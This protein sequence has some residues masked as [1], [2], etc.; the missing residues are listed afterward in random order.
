MKADKYLEKKSLDFEIV[1]QDN[2]TLDCDDAAQER[3]VETSQIAK[4]LIVD[5]DGEKIHCVLPGDRT[6]SA[7]KFG[8]NALV[9][10]EESLEITGQESG[11]VHPFS[12]QL[13]HRI[14][15]R[16]LEEEKISFTTGNSQKGVIIDTEKFREGLEKAGFNFQIGDIVDFNR[17]DIEELKSRGLDEEEARFVLSRGLEQEFEELNSDHDTGLVIGI[18]EEFG[19]H[20]LGYS[21][22]VA[23]EILSRANKETHMQKLVQAYDREGELPEEKDFSIEEA[24]EEV[25]SGNQDAVEDYREGKDSALNYLLGQVMKETNGK[26]DGGEARKTLMQKLEA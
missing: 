8:E 2:P 12:S 14:D 18:L 9:S 19:R 6:L 20:N 3:G 21:S 15:R 26:A 16:L 17:K 5:R 23:D 22:D 1:E 7:G 24:V 11:T 13:E 25:M 4:S 10:P